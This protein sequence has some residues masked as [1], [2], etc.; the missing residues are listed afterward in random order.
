MLQR[1][2][3]SFSAGGA[4][5]WP[6]TLTP[7]RSL[8]SINMHYFGCEYNFNKGCRVATLTY[9]TYFHTHYKQNEQ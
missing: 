5:K 4:K 9:A 6:P 7:F 1:K 8:L 2:Y 3:V